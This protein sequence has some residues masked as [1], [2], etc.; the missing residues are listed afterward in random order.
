MTRGATLVSR[1]K[2]PADFKRWLALRF[3]R[4]VAAE[5]RE[6]GTVVDTFSITTPELSAGAIAE[7]FAPVRAWAGTWTEL[8]STGPDLEIT[9]TD[10]DTRNFGRV[11]IPRTARALSADG[12]ARSIGRLDD[13]TKARKRFSSILAADIRL[14]GIAHH[15]PR[16]TAMAEPD[17]RVLCRFLSQIAAEGISKVRLRELPCAGMHT[18]FLEQHRALL[19]PAMA[20]LD[21]PSNPD[22]RSWA[23]KLGF[24]DDETHQFELRDLDGDLL[25]YPHFSLPIEQL[26]TNPVGQS[27]ASTLSGVVIVE[28]QATFRSLPAIAGVLAIFGRGNAV[29]TLGR[30]SWLTTRPLLY[31]GDL[32]HAG[33]LMVA[34]LRRDGLQRLDTALMDLETAISLKDYWVDDTSRPGTKHAYEGLT[35]EEHLAQQLMAEGPWRLEQ[36]RIPFDVWVNRLKRW[37]QSLG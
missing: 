36:E 5:L 8:G 17:F 20:S 1:W 9:W 31:A 22:A 15:W 30:A 2:S 16:F 21:I 23:G 37:R 33:F 4:L 14:A 32:D 11:R 19:V 13:L 26:A 28:N 18:K 34:A 29:R 25:P 6:P 7:H 10:W 24:I 35:D 3:D 12:A 27:A